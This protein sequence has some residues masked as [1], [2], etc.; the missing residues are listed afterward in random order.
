MRFEGEGASLILVPNTATMMRK[1]KKTMTKPIV[2][3]KSCENHIEVIFSLFIPENLIAKISQT[4]QRIISN[5]LRNF[6]AFDIAS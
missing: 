2:P 6:K 1:I 5:K 4:K 3:L